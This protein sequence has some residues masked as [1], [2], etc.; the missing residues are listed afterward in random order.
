MKTIQDQFIIG[1]ALMVV[2]PHKD[3]KKKLVVFPTGKWLHLETQ[4]M[5]ENENAELPV[6]RGR[7]MAFLGEGQILPVS[8][9]LY[10]TTLKTELENVVSGPLE[11][12]LVLVWIAGKEGALTLYDGSSF[13]ASLVAN[14]AIIRT[15]GNTDRTIA[16]R[17]HA[18]PTVRAIYHN[19]LTLPKTNWEYRGNTKTLTIFDI[20]GEESEIEILFSQTEN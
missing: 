3:A 18:C 1:N 13:S 15:S 6:Y 8:M 7:P 2:V 12:N 19:R 10:Q 5:Y 9:E 14:T 11:N 4:S 16:W 17:I 20:S